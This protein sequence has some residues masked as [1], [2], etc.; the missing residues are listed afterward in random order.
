MKKMLVMGDM[1]EDKD[2]PRKRILT[3]IEH[4]TDAT[5]ELKKYDADYL[6]EK[7]IE[8]YGEHMVVQLELKITR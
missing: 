5:K 4:E 1:T 6:W 2:T 7:A 8:D 3:F